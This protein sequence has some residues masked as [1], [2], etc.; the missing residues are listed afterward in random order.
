VAEDDHIK[1][2]EAMQSDDGIGDTLV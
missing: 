2:Q 1:I